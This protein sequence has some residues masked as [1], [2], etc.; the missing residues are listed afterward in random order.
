VQPWELAAREAI[1]DLVARYNGCGDAGDFDAM[2]ALFEPDAV[3]EVDDTPYAGT[4]AI[5]ALFEAAAGSTRR[6]AGG[7]VRHF[8]ATH[9]IDVASEDA[10]TGRCYFQ[11]LTEAGL[12]HWGR[13]TD[14]YRRRDGRWRFARRRVR[15]EGRTPA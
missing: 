1:R 15:V 6:R 7:F 9:R 14:A 11:V 5:R 12:D 2:L 10:A 13:Y 3:I 4:D 8:T